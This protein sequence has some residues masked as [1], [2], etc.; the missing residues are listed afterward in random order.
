MQVM[1]IFSCSF[2]FVHSGYQ[3]AMQQPVRQ[4]AEERYL[5]LD[6]T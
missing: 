4:D 2:A 3:Q 1:K 5:V 6:L